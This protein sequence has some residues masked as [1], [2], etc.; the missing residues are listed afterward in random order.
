MPLDRFARRCIREWRVPGC[1][2]GIVK[3]GRVV[4]AKGYGVRDAKR[5]LPVT[6]ET[7]FGIGSCT[8]AL[9][10]SAAALLVD[11]GLLDWDRPIRQYERNFG[12]LDPL[13]S[14]R[15]TLRDLL[16]HRTGLPQHSLMHAFSDLSRNQLLR[17]VRHLELARDFRSRFL[18]SNLSYVVAAAILEQVTGENYEGFVTRRLLC[19]LGM[20]RTMYPPDISLRKGISAK[21]GPVAT[22]YKGR[23]LG[24]PVAWSKGW[25]A[26]IDYP[27]IL[28]PGSPCRGAFSSILDMCRWMSFQMGQHG[29]AQGAIIT[30]TSLAEIHTPHVVAP[31]DRNGMEFLDA[32]YAMGWF[33]QPYRGFRTV[34]H[35]G[36]FCGFLARITLVPSESLGVAVLTNHGS[37]PVIDILT[38][39]ALDRLLGL[40]PIR[41][42]AR[43][44]KRCRL[45]SE[46]AEKDRTK[47]TRRSTTRPSRPL[48][49]YAGRY[50]H[51]GYGYLSITLNGS[52]L[53]AQFGHRRFDLRCLQSDTFEMI[54][55]RSGATV[56]QAS[57]GGSS[58]GRPQSISIPLEPMVGDVRFTRVSEGKA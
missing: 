56:A 43:H 7:L 35:G 44:K 1:A 53:Q 13:A 14:S 57:F 39:Y 12:L 9:T 51:P 19:P 28:G 30:G 3:G 58:A 50:E 16:T 17:R 23:P 21:G 33:V 41:W 25:P 55:A 45:D 11:D 10:A 34:F 32:C 20:S 24:R 29:S 18:Y 37:A 15:A 27:I 31:S 46:R 22:G 2:L 6:S 8:K 40:D 26:D 5:N 38:F 48:S 4:H 49:S 36:N 52:K 47:R 54:L 42:N